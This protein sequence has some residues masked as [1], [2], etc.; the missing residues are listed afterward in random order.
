MEKT[1][2][3]FLSRFNELGVLYMNEHSLAEI[4]RT[5]TMVRDNQAFRLFDQSPDLLLLFAIYLDRFEIYSQFLNVAFLTEFM[6]DLFYIALESLAFDICFDLLRYVEYTDV[7]LYLDWSITKDNIN[8]IETLI[9]LLPQDSEYP[10]TFF[11]EALNNPQVL[12]ILLRKKQYIHQLKNALEYTHNYESFKMLLNDHR[13]EYLPVEAERY[14]Y[15]EHKNLYSDFK[16]KYPTNRDRFQLMALDQELENLKN[17]K[18]EITSV[19]SFKR[20]DRDSEM[21]HTFMNQKYQT[22]IENLK[23]SRSKYLEQNKS[24][25]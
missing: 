9:N 25:N 17:E 13:V 22:D 20:G 4:G 14:L 2:E 18:G 15:D 24:G 19:L 11:Y 1:L 5:Y 7:E 6:N 23:K 12:E 8:L 3:D 10:D 21:L 16:A